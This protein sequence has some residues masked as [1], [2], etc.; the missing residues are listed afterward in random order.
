I[1]YIEPAEFDAFSSKIRE[2]FH[3]KGLI[4]STTQHMPSIL[5]AC[6]DVNNIV[7]YEFQNKLYPM[8]QTNQM[9]L[10]FA[11]LVNPAPPG[12]FCTTTSYRNEKHPIMG[13]HNLIFP[14]YEFEIHGGMDAW[15]CL[16]GNCWSILDLETSIVFHQLTTWMLRNDMEL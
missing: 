8:I 14:M 9:W 2:F 6:E 7:Y 3:K 11:I 13:R 16:R 12:Y 5:S 15:R 4:E 10:E 1:D